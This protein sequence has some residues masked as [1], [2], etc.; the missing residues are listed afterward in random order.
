[1][2]RQATAPTPVVIISGYASAGKTHLTNALLRRSSAT[3]LN[4]G[5]IVHRQ[6]EEYGISPNPIGI[7]NGEELAFCESVYDFGTGCICCSPKGELI[8][9]LSEQ[10]SRTGGPPLDLL[11]LRL[12]PLASPLIFA[13]AVCMGSEGC[14]DVASIVTVVES[15]LVGQH[16]GPTSPEWQARSQLVSADLVLLNEA[17]RDGR[18]N[19]VIGAGCA[20]R[21]GTLSMLRQLTEGTPIEQLPEASEHKRLDALLSRRGCFSRERAAS[22]DPDFARDFDADTPSVQLLSLSA[23][24]RRLGAG[25]AVEDGVLY[26]DKVRA[27]CDAL[28]S[29]G[30]AL[31]IK[32]V[33]EVSG[34]S[35]GE[36]RASGRP[37]RILIEGVEGEVC[38]RPSEGLAES[39]AAHEVANG[40]A[41]SK[42]FVLGRSIAVG[43]LR[44]QFHH[45]RVP[46]GY[47][48]AADADLHFGRRLTAAST[49]VAGVAPLP[50]C[51]VGDVP[52]VLIVHV[53]PPSEFVAL[54][55][56]A[57]G[58]APTEDAVTG[59]VE[60]PEHGQCVVL[61]DGAR[62][63]LSD[64]QALASGGGVA[65]RLRLVPTVC[66]GGSVYVL[67]AVQ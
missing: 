34:A 42:L 3:G 7:D 2:A 56:A 1:M 49:A 30:S 14:F 43:A 4:V 18:G 37:R 47:V 26:E 67:A 51:V 21:E 33:V 13:K 20:S 63:R 44:R 64:G 61:D 38:Y 58:E 46:E 28:A 57:Q 32:G 41:R 27:M 39:V 17:V 15:S 29:S 8:R 50:L 24:D 10:R 52:G 54:R 35:G 11:I 40:G 16:L 48:F 25:C 22:I 6:A 19:S 55:G 9:L 62:I 66:V 31:R 12:G 59:V 45:C 5:V 23:H 53:G 36:G 60:D 65:P